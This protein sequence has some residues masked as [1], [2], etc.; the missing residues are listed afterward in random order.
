[1]LRLEDLCCGYGRMRAVSGLSLEVPE[2]SVFA[3]IGANG[4]GKTSTL[5]AIAGHVEIQGGRVVFR[6]QDLTSLP[7]I[8]RVAA[9]IAL[10]PEGRRLF[11]ELSVTENLIVGGYARPPRRFAGNRDFVLELFPRLAERLH[12]R[13]GNLSGGEQQM[14][15]IGRALMAEP[16]LLLVD[17]ISLGLMPTM[18]DSCYAALATL[19]A[20]GI[21]VL[22]VE[23]S[24]QRAL[25]VA[26]RICVL[27]S[28][29]SVY[30]GSAAEARADPGLIDTYLGLGAG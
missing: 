8:A 17:E 3:L 22:L 12:L 5:M 26:D 21:T 30:H 20:R 15:A 7:P 4:A 10:I 11:V 14:V 18:V 1:M 24:T 27:E 9:G 16:K 2:G 25:S 6:D 29:R 13:A 19:K 28:G 23:Q